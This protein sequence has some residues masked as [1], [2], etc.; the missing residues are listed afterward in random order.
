MQELAIEEFAKIT[1]DDWSSVCKHVENVESEYVRKEHIM[2][3]YCEEFTINFNS[4][5]EDDIFDFSS[6]ED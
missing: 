4:D 3:Q 5:T 1:P 2:D 6:D